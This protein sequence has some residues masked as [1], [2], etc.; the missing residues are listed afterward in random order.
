M[1]YVPLWLGRQPTVLIYEIL[2]MVDHL[3]CGC[4]CRGLMT[5]LSD[6][7]R[8]EIPRWRLRYSA[9]LVFWRF[10]LCWYAVITG[11]SPSSQTTLVRDSSRYTVLGIV[12]LRFARFRCGLSITTQGRACS[13]S[14]R[15]ARE[16]KRVANLI[17]DDCRG[18]ICCSSTSGTDLQAPLP[19]P[20]P[21]LYPC[22][23]IRP[24]ETSFP[25]WLPA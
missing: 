18:G 19:C 22:T 25:L 4:S 5:A 14:S 16:G 13:H 9:V 3:I 7:S 2:L 6:Q 11:D 12:R 10:R 23:C 1:Y 24:T 17:L 21:R 8:V 20:A 15:L